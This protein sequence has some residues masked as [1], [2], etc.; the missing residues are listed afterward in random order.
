MLLSKKFILIV[1]ITIILLACILIWVNNLVRSDMNIRILIDGSWMKPTLL[2]VDGDVLTISIIEGDVINQ[3]QDSILTYSFFENYNDFSIVE[4]GRLELSQWQLNRVRRL[5]RN[6]V[7]NGFDRK[8]EWVGRSGPVHYVW[9][10]ADGSPIYWSLYHPHINYTLR[11]Q[12]LNGIQTLGW[13]YEYFY[14]RDLLLLTYRLIELSPVIIGN[15][16]F[17]L[18][19]PRDF[20]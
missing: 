2:E 3:L 10:V 18:Q 15:E 7:A 4:I 8:F 1:A 5:T 12:N 13:F 19:T 6:V 14:D 16:N 17:P 11:M 20:R 9:M